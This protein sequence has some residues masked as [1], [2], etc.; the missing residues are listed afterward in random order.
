VRWRLPR[1]T[2][3][4]ST[5]RDGRWALYVSVPANTE[6][7]LHDLEAVCGGFPVVYVAAPDKPARA[8]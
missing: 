4:I 1:G 2:S 8:Y 7:P 6:V 3:G 5:T